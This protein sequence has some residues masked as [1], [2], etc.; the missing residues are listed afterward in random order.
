MEPRGADHAHKLP[1]TPGGIPGGEV[2]PQEQNKPDNPSQDRLCVSTYIHKQTKRERRVFSQFNRLGSWT[3][4][5]GGVDHSHKLL[6]TPHGSLGIE[7]LPQEQNDLTI[8]L[9]IDSTSTLT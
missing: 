3:M 1:E 2:L 7:V 8:Y 9:K 4:D 5:P 6:G